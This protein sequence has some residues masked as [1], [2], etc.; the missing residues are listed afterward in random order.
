MAA[1]PASATRRQRGPGPPRAPGRRRVPRPA[2]LHPDRNEVLAPPRASCRRRARGRTPRHPGG[3]EASW[4]RPTA[5]NPLRCPAPSRRQR[6]AS[7][8]PAGP[9][10]RREPRAALAPRAET[11]RHTCVIQLSRSGSVSLAGNQSAPGQ[12]REPVRPS[13]EA[14]PFRLVDARESPEKACPCRGW[15]PRTFPPRPQPRDPHGDTV[16]AESMGGGWEHGWR[17]DRT[18]A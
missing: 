9:G 15:R 10:Q 12:R 18:P 8:A 1:G 16:G 5:R 7:W 13:P 17:E 14:E 11:P 6:K 2:N 3:N 4:P